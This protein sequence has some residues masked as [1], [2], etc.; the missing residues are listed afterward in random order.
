M[1]ARNAKKRAKFRPAEPQPQSA[2][3]TLDAY[4][5]D[6]GRAC[7]NCGGFPVVTG[8]KDGRVV[9]DTGICGIC[10]WGESACADPANW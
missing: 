6:Y 1:A 8:V 10:T 5:P 2:M 7:E 9:L 3:T 4:V